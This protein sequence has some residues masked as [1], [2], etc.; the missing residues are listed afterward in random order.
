MHSKHES[1]CCNTAIMQIRSVHVIWQLVQSTMF[2]HPFSTSEVTLSMSS[3]CLVPI[4][5]FRRG[6]G[7]EE[8]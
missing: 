3:R 2:W 7:M 5:D 4:A 6:T 1:V 8:L